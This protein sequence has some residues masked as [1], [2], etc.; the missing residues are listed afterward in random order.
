MA[1]R[2]PISLSVVTWTPGRNLGTFDFWVS[3]FVYGVYARAAHGEV[4]LKSKKGEKKRAPSKLDP[5]TMDKKEFGPVVQLLRFALTRFAC[6][7]Q[8]NRGMSP[9]TFLQR[10]KDNLSSQQCSWTLDSDR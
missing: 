1:V 7:G 6:H 5:M 10:D 8:R 3:F 2:A 9:F 4:G